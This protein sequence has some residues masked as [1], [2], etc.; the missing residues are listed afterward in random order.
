[1]RIYETK[2]KFKVLQFHV[3]FDYI[4][5]QHIKANNW[6]VQCIQGHTTKMYRQKYFQKR[7]VA[8]INGFTI[9]INLDLQK[10]ISEKKNIYTIH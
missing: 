4:F 9:N 1:M 7:I 6:R 3:Q 5:M 8:I 10:K 2:I